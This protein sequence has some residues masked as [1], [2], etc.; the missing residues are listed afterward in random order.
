MLNAIDRQTLKGFD[1]YGLRDALD[2]LEKDRFVARVWQHDPDLWKQGDSGHAAVIKNRLGWLGVPEMMEGCVEDLTSFADGVRAEGI[3][4]IVLL[5]MGGSSL[6]PI[7]LR[8]TFGVRQGF[9]DL[10][11]LDSTS[12]AAIEEVESKVDLAK[13]LFVDASKSGT[14]LESHCFAECFFAKAS[15]N[16]GSPA[17]AAS[18]FASITDPGTP[19]E[20]TARRRGYRRVFSN[21]ADIGGRYSALSYFGLVPGAVAGV[22][23]A[24]LLDRASR[25]AQACAAGVAAHRHPAV[26][27]GAALALAALRGSRDKITFF[28]SPQIS[29]IG[30]WLEQL[31]AESTGKESKGLVPVAD[32]PIGAASAYGND[33]VFVSLKCGDDS[34]QE[35]LCKALSEAGHPVVRIHLRDAVDLGEE[36]FRWEFATAT[37]GALLGIDAFDEPNV[38]ESKDNTGRILAQG[39]KPNA[40]AVKPDDD[41]AF[42]AHFALAGR[43][44]YI[45]LQAF[46][47]PSRHR[48]HV[49]QRAR[50]ALRDATRAATTLGYG[51]RFLH[52]TGQLHKGGPNTGVFV[53]FVGREG[54]PLAIPGEPFDF[55]TLIAAQGLGDL[56]S[57]HD[58]GR[59]VLSVDLGDDIDSGLEA[60]A[61]SVERIAPGLET[62]N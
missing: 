45:A 40:S 33:R 51:P 32:E 6:C 19:L 46:V 11:V 54:P 10:V 13:T 28:S 7:V 14:T 43:A 26:M 62:S 39:V 31:I 58:H 9:P 48:T 25:M 29:T 34:A 1:A 50:A 4:H 52:S 49:L 41:K 30:M 12:P 20:A 37:A 18:H 5:G 2:R 24:A 56:Q 42:A 36:F 47:R 22:D 21:P 3:K 27:L 35:A 44:D 57:L 53:Q 61:Q 17:A 8:E 59:R 55:G 23:I 15:A 60:F 16:M 38:K